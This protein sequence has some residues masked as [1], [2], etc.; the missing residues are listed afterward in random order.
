MDFAHDRVQYFSTGEGGRRCLDEISR[1]G[2]LLFYALQRVEMHDDSAEENGE[3][4]DPSQAMDELASA[5]RKNER[6]EHARRVIAALMRNSGAMDS[7]FDET[8]G[9]KDFEAMAMRWQNIRANKQTSP[10]IL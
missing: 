2:Y 7:S 10:T 8:S 4:L 6:D 9:G 1:D 3:G 5:L